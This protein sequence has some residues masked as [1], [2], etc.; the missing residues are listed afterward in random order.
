[1]AEWCKRCE[2]AIWAYCLMPNHVHLIAV[3]EKEEG[4]R[5][6]I[7]ETH[8]RY[9][10]HVNFPEGWRGYLWQ[11]RFAS[12]PMDEA[13]LLTAARYIELNPVRAHMVGKPEEYRWSSAR[14][15]LSDQDDSLVTVLP[16]LEIVGDWKSFLC[17]DLPGSEMDILRRHERTGRPLGDEVFIVQWE[18][19][20]KRPLHRK[21]PGPKTTAKKN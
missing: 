11:G 18:K 9:S 16:L 1:M 2:V 14:A 3:P 20:L 6:A 8:R 21:K 13:H 15:H 10:R 19:L 7:G 4:L 5:Q 17:Q 12:Y